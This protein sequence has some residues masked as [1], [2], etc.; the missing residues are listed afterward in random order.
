MFLNQHEQ[1]LL[2]RSMKAHSLDLYE[3]IQRNDFMEMG[4]LVRKTWQQNQLLDSG[5]NPDTVRRITD[6]ID[7]LCLGYKLPGAGGGGFLYMV[8]KD[9]EAATR[10]KQVIQQ[11]EQNPNARFVDMT[12]SKKGLQISRS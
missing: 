7:D 9:S 12:L 1:L 3:A 10:I 4:K 11:S 6:L 8:A 2:L 5:T